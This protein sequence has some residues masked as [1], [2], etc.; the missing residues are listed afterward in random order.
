MI[1]SNAGK[2]AKGINEGFHKLDLTCSSH[3]DNFRASMESRY[4]L[5]YEERAETEQRR[6]HLEECAKE[7][8]R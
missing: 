7:S 1:R 3:E 6:L 8:F 2:D 5:N 4:E